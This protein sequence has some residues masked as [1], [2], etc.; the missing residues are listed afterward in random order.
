MVSLLFTLQ[1]TGNAMKNTIDDADYIINWI[2]LLLY[3][4]MLQI[5]ITPTRWF[6]AA[7]PKYR[8]PRAKYPRSR[9]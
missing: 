9:S 3:I 5:L 2:F 1:R 6:P 8:K 4:N 7:F